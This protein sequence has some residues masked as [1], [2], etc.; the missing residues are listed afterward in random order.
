MPISA[1]RRMMAG[2]GTGARGIKFTPDANTVLW[3]PGQDDAYSAT[4]RDRSGNGNN[5]T[6]T[7]AV[8]TRNN[9][10]TWYLD[11]DGTN[12]KIQLANSSVTSCRISTKATFKIWVK[13]NDLT[14]AE[15]TIAGKDTNTLALEYDLEFYDIDSDDNYHVR[16]L[17]TDN[18][19]GGDNA[20]RMFCQTGNLISDTLWHH[21]V[22]AIDLTKGD[23]TDVIVYKD[24]G[25][26][27]CPKAAGSYIASI[28]AGDEV[29][30]IAET[31]RLSGVGKSLK[32]AT[33]LPMLSLN[34]V[35]TPEQVSSSYQQERHLL[36]V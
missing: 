36:G 5:G 10:G 8:W 2:G 27:A 31:I 3:L 28:F 6:I 20:H 14:T 34:S 32:G 7:Q 30:E 18:G 23:D 12:D 35:W 17:A 1:T 29:L 26:N 15:H 4:I 21:I 11:F 33:A 19:N 24:G 16:L 22:W 13:L 9:Q 25:A